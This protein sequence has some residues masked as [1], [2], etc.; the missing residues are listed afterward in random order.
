MLRAA[1][2][3]ERCDTVPAFTGAFGNLMW[4]GT[5]ARPLQS[6]ATKL[7]SLQLPHTDGFIALH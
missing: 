6:R 1:R 5:R 7:N 2:P 3:R 4:A